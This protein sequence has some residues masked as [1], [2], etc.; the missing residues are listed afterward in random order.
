MAWFTYLVSTYGPFLLKV[1]NESDQAISNLQMLT[2]LCRYLTKYSYV[3]PCIFELRLIYTASQEF[4]P[5][6]AYN[7]RLTFRNIPDWILKARKVKQ[8]SHNFDFFQTQLRHHRA[9]LC[10]MLPSRVQSEELILFT[11]TPRLERNLSIIISRSEYKLHVSHVW[12]MQG[13]CS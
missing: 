13:Y 8:T 6:S 11:F 5:K 9:K 4:Y 2:W 12:W 10:P 3:P 1:L 7:F